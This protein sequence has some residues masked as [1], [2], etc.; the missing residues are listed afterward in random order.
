MSALE[1][2]ARSSVVL[3]AA[4]AAVWV[5]RKQP[6]A[7][8]HGLLAA[9][10]LLAALQPLLTR[11]VPQVTI[12]TAKWAG[13]R[14]QTDFAVAN[15]TTD[16]AFLA[17][18]SVVAPERFDWL[19]VTYQVWAVG[20]GLSVSVLILG[21]LWLVWL[22]SRAHD[23]G[24]HWQHEADDLRARLAIGR[25][26]RIAVTQHP[27]LLVTWGALTPVI[28]LPA[29]ADAWP[30]ERI[31]LVLAHE[32]AHLARRDW[33]MQLLAETGRAINWFNPLFWIA[34]SRLR[35]ESEHACDDIVLELG[36]SATSYAS[37]LIELARSFRVHGRTWLPAPSIAR[38]STLERRVRA[39]LN[40]QVDRRPVSPLRRAVLVLGLIALAVPI[41]AATFSA[42][43]PA[44]VLRDPMGRVLPGATVRLSA[45]G[46]DAIHETQSDS[47]GTFQFG[48]VPDGEYM[49]SARLPG[50]QT[51]RQRVSVSASMAPL[52]FAMRVGTLRETV[53]VRGGGGANADTGTAY[54]PR[55]APTTPKC[56]STELGGNLK[57]PMKLKDV[58]PRYK[59]EW[60]AAELTGNVLLQVVIGKDGK[61]RDLEV[62]S[63]GNADLEEEAIAAVS[64]WEFSP[65]WLN[66][67]P[68]EVRM[69]VTVS[70]DYDR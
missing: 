51:A 50:F 17:P 70:F 4:L 32:F 42:G 19:S 18:V 56:G 37:Q 7:L 33:L 43:A 58:R 5:F 55:Y 25:C 40:P 35:R 22:G 20:A 63:P 34:C 24:S 64:Q 47:T 36:I 44:G 39:M 57:P 46:A 27:A 14:I 41:A 68:I 69:F 10:T 31:R 67:E 9:A 8:R 16:V 66:C 48:E 1:L 49:L 11:V 65:T 38:P 60:S 62:V 6:A 15:V 21:V 26:V 2:I 61:I 12:G 23:A 13:E 52:D 59:A 28:L 54:T 29:G 3:A 45:I 53:T 30:T